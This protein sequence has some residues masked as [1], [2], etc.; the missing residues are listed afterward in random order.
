MTQ[1]PEE[2]AVGGTEPVG[3]SDDNLEAIL[4]EHFT[5][6]EQDDPVETDPAEG[7]EETDELNENDPELEAEEL[8]PIDPPVSLTAEEKEAFKNL[9]REAQ[10]FTA[11]RIGELE[12]GFQSKAQEAAQAQV[13]ARQ[14]ALQHIAQVQAQAAEQLERYAQQFTVQPPSAE[15]YRVN[16]EAYAQQFEAFQIYTAQRDSAQ[17]EAEQARAV[18]AQYES[19]IERQEHQAFV[20]EAR[21]IRD[22]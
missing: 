2:G 12:K 14:E 13:A 10:E 9:P 6:E 19:E 18:Q 22:R 5:D 3:A 15:L 7:E 11:R 20:E 17:R 8:P 4:A 21:H 1:Q 16:P